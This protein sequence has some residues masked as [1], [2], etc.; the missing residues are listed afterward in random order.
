ME[1]SDRQEDNWSL[2]RTRSIWLIVLIGASY[3]VW[4]SL[5]SLQSPFYPKEAE[6]KG[7]SSSQYGFVFGISN[8]VALLT[9]PIFGA[10]GN[11]IG[12]KYVYNFGTFTQAFA[13]ISFG[14]LTNI[15]NL[16]VFLAISYFLR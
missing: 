3:I 14:F 15:E 2:S 10:Y 11:K 7:A 5:I 8:L 9:A 1:R 6:T 12:A 13:A 16:K 4:G